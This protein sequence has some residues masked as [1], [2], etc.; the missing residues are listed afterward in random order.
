MAGA[1]NI[2]AHLTHPKDDEME[3]KWRSSKEI[4]GSQ[5]PLQTACTFFPLKTTVFHEEVTDNKFPTYFSINMNAEHHI[6]SKSKLWAENK[7]HAFI[8]FTGSGKSTLLLQVVVAFI[9]LMIEKA[10]CMWMFVLRDK[11]QPFFQMIIDQLQEEFGEDSVRQYSVEEFLAFGAQRHFPHV[12]AGQEKVYHSN[13]PTT[14]IFFDDAIIAGNQPEAKVMA[15]LI[16][17]LQSTARHHNITIFTTL[18]STVYPSNEDFNLMKRQIFTFTFPCS[19]ST[20][21][22]TLMRIF[23]PDRLAMLADNCKGVVRNCAKLL[24]DRNQLHALAEKAKGRSRYV[25]MQQGHDTFPHSALTIDPNA[26]TVYDTSTG[27]PTAIPPD[28]K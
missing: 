7:I 17:S 11:K 18:H 25:L 28:K 26:S 1:S 20:Q 2:P 22:S 19:N 13:N 10:S 8:G 12:I 4:R 14:L 5:P 6:V 9:P 21:G 16:N 24:M 23:A 15:S 27:V 3:K